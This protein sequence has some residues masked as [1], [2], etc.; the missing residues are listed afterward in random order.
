M[1]P[2]IFVPSPPEEDLDDVEKYSLEEEEEEDA[3]DCC[4]DTL[5]LDSV[6]T[7]SRK[8]DD[9]IG[10]DEEEVPVI[11]LSARSGPDFGNTVDN[12]IMLDRNCFR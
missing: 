4:C 7:V 3:D 1:L 5:L 8:G 11:L 9:I 6:D 2:I 10:E 12:E